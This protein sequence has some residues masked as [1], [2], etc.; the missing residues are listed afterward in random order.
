MKFYGREAEKEELGKLWLQAS[1]G[2]KLAVITGRRRLGKTLLVKEFAK[3]HNYL[4]LFIEK[5]PEALLCQDLIS[6]L[7]EKISLPVLGEITRFK[8]IFTLILEYAKKEKLIL[9]LDEFQEFFSINPSIYSEIQN[10][11]DAYKEFSEIFLITIGSIYSLMHKI[12][13]DEKEPLFGRADRIIKLA[14]FPIQTLISLLEDYEITEEKDVFAFYVLTGGVPKYLELLLENGVKSQPEILDFMLT[15]FSPF[16]EE[17]RNLLTMEFGR[18]YG[19][20]FAIL[21]LMSE[22]KTSRP[23]IESILGR[24]VGSYIENLKDTYNLIDRVTP[25]GEKYSPRLVK[26]ALKDPFL[27]FWF[28]FIYRNQ[29]AVE[30]QNFSYIKQIIERDYSTYCGRFLERFFIEILAG[31]KKYNRIGSYWEEKNLNEID[32]VA[33]NDLEKKLFIAEVKT[34]PK[35]LSLPELHLKAYNLLR[36]FP[37]Y[38]PEFV[39]LTLKDVKK[40]MTKAVDN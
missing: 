40:Y 16:L 4:Y 26:F 1:S 33:V 34:N 32:I 20:Y 14:P 17:G 22:G 31:Q 38:Q 12:F 30:L 28:R 13:Q 11:W 8:D 15:E 7:Q 3:N 23:A 35:N 24:S 36:Q 19:T 27:N 37:G 5:K 2:A 21:Q 29:S 39:G 10:L 18:E 25:I 9:I 6:I